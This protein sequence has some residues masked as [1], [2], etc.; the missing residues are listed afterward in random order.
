[1]WSMAMGGMSPGDVL[2]AATIDGARYLN[3]DSRLGSLE[4]GKLADF[5]VLEKNP[6]DDIRNT[7]S[8]RL[9]SV[10]GR[11]Y[12]VATMNQIAPIERSRGKLWFEREGQNTLWNA[13]NWGMTRPEDELPRCPAHTDPH[14]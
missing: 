2:R 5:V 11:L 13:E 3:M 12:D 1:M 6:L 8:V 9:V 10:D 14:F 7:D 4:A